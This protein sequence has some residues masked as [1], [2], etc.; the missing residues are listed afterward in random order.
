MSSSGLSVSIGSQRSLELDDKSDGLAVSEISRHGLLVRRAVVAVGGRVQERTGSNHGRGAR[1]S[2]QHWHS[3]A[4]M[5]R[6]GHGRWSGLQP[7]EVTQ[8]SW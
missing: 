4:P 7:L 1:W 8:T 3:S 5:P 6:K 2:W